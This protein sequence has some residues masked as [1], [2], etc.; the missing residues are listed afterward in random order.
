MSLVAGLIARNVY[1][2]SEMWRRAA[3]GALLGCVAFGPVTLAV[4]RPLVGRR[5]AY[6]DRMAAERYASLKKAVEQTAAEAGAPGRPCDGTEVENPYSGP[7]F[8]DQD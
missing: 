6:N 5:M 2:S 8:S 7:S 1:T 4:T 3:W